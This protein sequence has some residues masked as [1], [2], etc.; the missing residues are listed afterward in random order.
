M[1]TFINM[2]YRL[3]AAGMNLD[4]AIDEV[5][6]GYCLTPME[7]ERLAILVKG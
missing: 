2:V 7:R 1:R 5:A 6:A 4:K 3:K